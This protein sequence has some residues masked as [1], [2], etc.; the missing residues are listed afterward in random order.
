M[1]AKANF[2]QFKLGYNKM[3]EIDKNVLSITKFI[4]ITYSAITG[5]RNTDNLSF[6]IQTLN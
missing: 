2:T 5:L 4:N 1:N 3:N 6:V